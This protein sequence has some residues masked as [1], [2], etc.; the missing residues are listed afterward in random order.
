MHTLLTRTVGVAVLAIVGATVGCGGERNTAES[1]PPS[2]RGPTISE[3]QNQATIE[4]V[5]KTVAFTVGDPD[6]PLEQLR[7]SALSSN[8][9]V[10][11]TN[12]IIFEGVGAE[13]KALIQPTLYAFG[14]TTI[15]IRVSDGLGE[16]N[17]SF[18]FVVSPVTE[19]PIFNSNAVWQ[20][21]EFSEPD[22]A[23]NRS[24]PTGAQTNQ[25]SAAAGSGR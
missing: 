18:Q 22:G 15:T 14:R 7:L 1:L 17:R 11:A 10:V 24:Q 25:T 16:T 8:P 13:R 9:A 6:T 5:S 12:S 23:A 3:I 21:V 2:Q 4:D 19:P 20:K